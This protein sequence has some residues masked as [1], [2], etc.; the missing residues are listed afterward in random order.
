VAGR[1]PPISST[2]VIR[3]NC[4]HRIGNRDVLQRGYYLSLL[5]PSFIYVRYRCSRCKR[6]GEKL[7]QEEKWD[8]AVLDQ[9]AVELSEDEL[10]KFK[11]MG[12]IG[13]DEIVDFHFAL[14]NLDELPEK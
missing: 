12:P 10:H 9:A 2:T 5:G 13:A 7:V 4:G 8:P 14:A 6:V 11:T 1:E 3:C